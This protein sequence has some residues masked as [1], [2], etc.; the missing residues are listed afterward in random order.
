MLIEIENGFTNVF[1]VL[2]N[3]KILIIDDPVLTPV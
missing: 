3:E 1:E 2:L